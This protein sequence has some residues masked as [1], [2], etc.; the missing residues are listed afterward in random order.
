MSHFIKSSFAI[1]VLIIASLLTGC[2]SQRVV[3]KSSVMEYLYPKTV[4]EHPTP[5]IPHLNLPLRVGIAFVPES[6]SRSYGSSNWLGST[7]PTSFSEAK[8]TEILDRVADNFKQLE[9]VDS[10]QVIP[11]AYLTPGG[12]FTNLSQLQTMYGIDVIALVSYDQTQFTDDNA[13]ALSYWTIVGAYV[14]SGSKNDTSTLIDTAVF[15]ISS[16]QLLFRAPGKSVVSGRSTPVNLS[17]E[18]RD[19]SDLGFEK[20]ANDMIKNLDG[21]LNRFTEKLKQRPDDVKVNYR[22]GYGGGSFGYLLPSILL[23]GVLAKHR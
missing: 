2:A 19:D 12:S 13:L 6:D 14:V 17:E 21:E 3:N 22:E 8:K 23:L 11:S 18:L 9:F 15:D 16:K 20:A 5:T 4:E 10:I 1:S 7:T